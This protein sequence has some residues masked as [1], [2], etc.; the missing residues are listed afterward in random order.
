MP[1]VLASVHIQSLGVIHSNAI[2]EEDR[3]TT[4]L[5]RWAG[6]PLWGG[7]QIAPPATGSVIT[8]VK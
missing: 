7:P 5:R 6:A 1:N 3:K 8:N 2:R 4:K